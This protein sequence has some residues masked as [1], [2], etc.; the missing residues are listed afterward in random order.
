MNDVPVS[1][2]GDFNDLYREQRREYQARNA[3]KDGEQ[4]RVIRFTPL[5]VSEFPEGKD[6]NE[7]QKKADKEEASH[8]KKTNNIKRNVAAITIA[9]V[10]AIATIGA[11]DAKNKHQVDLVALIREIINNT[12]GE[13][14]RE[15][16][17]SIV[18]ANDALNAV[19][20][21]WKKIND[22]SLEIEER[23]KYFRML[24]KSLFNY[25]LYFA[26]AEQVQWNYA[27]RK[28]PDNTISNEELL[29]GTGILIPEYERLCSELEKAS[30]DEKISSSETPDTPLSTANVSTSTQIVG[31]Q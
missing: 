6:D 23:K 30:D 25:Q 17:E 12:S 28:L 18:V 1:S 11:L 21:S 4:G 22:K 10:G 14:N 20:E 19:H 16:L 13:M 31:S 3:Q 9:I 7:A 29:R 5:A 2:L 27:D 8:S 15:K 26:N 24:K